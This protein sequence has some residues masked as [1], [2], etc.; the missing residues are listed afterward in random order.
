M[1]TPHLAKDSTVYQWIWPGLSNIRGVGVCG[2][3]DHT[4]QGV[5]PPPRSIIFWCPPQQ[6]CARPDFSDWD[7]DRDLVNS[8]SKVETETE[9]FNTGINFW[10]WDWDFWFQSQILRLRL[11]LCY[12]GL[13]VWDWDW[14]QLSLKFWDWDWDFWVCEKTIFFYLEI[15]QM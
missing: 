15:G 12:L 3:G 8:V 9:T 7:W 10:D 5:P 4:H 2:L 13:K 6:G 11:R 14:D 1:T